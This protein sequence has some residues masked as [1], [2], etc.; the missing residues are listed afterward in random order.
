M[1][2]IKILILE[3]D[4]EY[5]NNLAMQLTKIGYD[6][7]NILM[8]GSIKEV[9]AIAHSFEADIILIDLQIEDCHGLSTYQKVNTIYPNATFIVLSGNND[10]E[11]ALDIVKQGA[12]DYL[13]KSDIDAKILYKSLQYSNERKALYHKLKS[14]E[15]TYKNIFNQSP[16]PMLVITGSERVIEEVNAAATDLYEMP[17]SEMI[18]KPLLSLQSAEADSDLQGNIDHFSNDFT[19]NQIHRSKTNKTLHVQIF[20]KELQWIHEKYICLIVDKTKEKHFEENKLKLIADV[21]ENEKK[22]VALELHDG[23]VQTLGLLSIQFGCFKF[24]DS[25]KEQQDQ[26]RN[27]LK[28]AI[29]ETRILAYHLSPLDLD[30][31]L[32][33]GFIKLIKRI[34]RTGKYSVTCEILDNVKESD[35]GQVDKFNIYRIVQ[36]FLN[37]STKHS[38]STSFSLKISK[39]EQNNVLITAEDFGCGFDLS[40]DGIGLGIKN[41]LHRIEIGKIRG[42]ITS[43]IN[44]GTKLQLILNN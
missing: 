35:L 23:L 6:D 9:Q 2:D 19:V 21:Q 31:G 24:N 22:K 11:L 32:L 34:N 44:Q 40:Q 3:D 26:F 17:A 30:E 4:A 15:V 37:N 43:E 10:E 27:Q 20:G 5:R 25:Q 1:K 33:E 36:E 39:N 8:A 12:Q 7:F 29:D 18:G 41:I 28:D 16:L 13:L 38:G 42:G 14:S